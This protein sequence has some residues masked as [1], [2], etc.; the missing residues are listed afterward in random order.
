[1]QSQFK[2]KFIIFIAIVI[3]IALFGLLG[4]QLVK[5]NKANEQISN[6]QKQIESLQQQLDYYNS[7]LPDGEHDA[8]TGGN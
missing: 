8:I 6:Q 1:M 4:F 2:V 3:P 7:K 5:I